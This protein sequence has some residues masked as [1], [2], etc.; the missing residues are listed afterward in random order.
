MTGVNWSPYVQLTEGAVYDPDETYYLDDKHYG[1]EVWNENVVQFH[2]LVINGRLYVKT[3]EPD[4]KIDDEFITM[5]SDSENGEKTLRVTQLFADASSSAPSPILSGIVYVDNER[6]I[7]ESKINQLQTYYPNLKFIFKNVTKAY[8]AEFLFMNPD[9]GIEEYVQF[10]DGSKLPSVQKIRQDQFSAN[11]WFTNPFSLYNP[12]RAH[13]DFVGWS[14]NPNADPNSA[15]V[16][17]NVTEWQALHLVE[18]Q[19]NYVYYAIFAIHSYSIS[20]Y[21]GNGQLFTSTQLDYGIVGIPEPAAVPSKDD[22]ELA[23]DR[24]YGFVGYTDNLMTNKIVDLSYETVRGKMDYYAVFEEMSVYDNIQPRFFRNGGLWGRETNKIIL[25]LDRRVSGKITVPATW[26]DEFGV[27]YIVA[28]IDNSFA[29]STTMTNVSPNG[30]LLTHVFFEKGTQIQSF[31][32]EA[33]RGYNR[34]FDASLPE[35]RLKFVEFPSTL[36]SIGDSAFFAADALDYGELN[37]DP[38]LRNVVDVSGSSVQAIGT[39]C[40]QM[41]F[42]DGTSTENFKI[43]SKVKNIGQNAFYNIRVQIGVITIGTANEPSLLSFDGAPV[44]IF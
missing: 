37:I 25:Q 23:L 11:T 34:I 42:K 41:A 29:S 1:L 31:N 4:V 21:D 28:A 26:T 24:T 35:N 30:D 12:Q 5:I 32:Q 10:K 17:R 7:E 6:A 3:A 19:Y 39:G 15:E 8:S 22:S 44:S 40:F 27:E 13:Y 14:T 9:T 43:G 18:D 33:F 38:N 36:T 2:N 16:I 20:F